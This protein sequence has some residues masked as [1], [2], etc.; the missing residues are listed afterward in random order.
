M[1]ACF[2]R[3]AE[4]N[5]LEKEQHSGKPYNFSSQ[6]ASSLWR[7]P[8][9]NA[10]SKVGWKWACVLGL[11]LY[12]VLNDQHLSPHSLLTRQTV[13]PHTLPA[14][15]PFQE[16]TDCLSI[17]QWQ[18]KTAT[19]SLRIFTLSFCHFPLFMYLFYWTT[20]VKVEDMTF[21]FWAL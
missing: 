2:Y 21:H 8:L 10:T 6:I 7:I 5:A 15:S 16:E 17:C 13:V 9:L 4:W 20:C 12:N 3:A 18:I 1:L 14:N 19:L 11:V